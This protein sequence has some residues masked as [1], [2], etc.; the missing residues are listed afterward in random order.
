MAETFVSAIFCWIKQYLI[1][2]SAIVI[3][4]AY[5]L[6]VVDRISLFVDQINVYTLILS[7]LRLF[8]LTSQT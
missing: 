8:C 2:F 1:R 7:F 6:L 5:L 4:K 3:F